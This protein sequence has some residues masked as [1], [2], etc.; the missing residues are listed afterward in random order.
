VAASQVVSMTDLAPAV[1]TAS[2]TIGASEFMLI[3]DC[4]GGPITQALPDPTITPGRPLM[5]K[6]Q[7]ATGNALTL[8]GLLDGSSTTRTMSVANQVLLL[9]SDGTSWRVGNFRDADQ[10]GNQFA[11]LTIASAEVRY[12]A[13]QSSLTSTVEN[14]ISNKTRRSMAVKGFSIKCYSNQLVSGESIVFTVR[15]NGA[16]TGVTLTIADTS[17]NPTSA[18][19]DSTGAPVEF[20]AGD[21]VDIVGRA[22]A[23]GASRTCSFIISIEV[24]YL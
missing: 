9:F 13:V 5:V 14:S 6:K 8:S 1:R 10:W 23:L 12:Y 3:Y 20:Q 4:T 17:V 21:T 2:G 19:V 15:K 22:S 18:F 16:D 24:L 7:D 11:S